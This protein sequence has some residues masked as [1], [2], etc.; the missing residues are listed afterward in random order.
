[1]T[2]EERVEERA[3]YEVLLEDL[4]KDVRLIAEGHVA[5]TERLDRTEARF[6]QR[7]EQV[8]QQIM[9]LDVKFT[10]KI[11]ALDAKVTQKIDALDAKVTQ[12]VDALDTK[13]SAEL[14][15]IATHL[16]LNGAP[17]PQKRSQRRRKTRSP[18]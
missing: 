11:D 4:Q 18:R 5:L 12:Q 13:L 10:Q 17:R 6:E 2:L 7:F 15:R 9:V 14:S 8:E 1:M 3:R 16:G